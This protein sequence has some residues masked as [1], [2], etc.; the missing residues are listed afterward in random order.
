MTELDE[1]WA[2]FLKNTNRDSE[3]KCSGDLCFEGKGFVQSQINSIVLAGQ[4]QAFFTTLAT[5]TIDNE[6]L[7]IS[8]ELYILVDNQNKPL[9]VLEI[10]SVNII[11]FN[12][13]TFEMVK[14]EGECATMGEWKEKMQEYI[15]DEAHVLGFEYSPDIKLVYQTFKV[16][17]K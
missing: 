5:F 10:E 13:V 8:G 17:Y 9:C 12:E 3:D 14:K 7:P 16:I 6:P 4:K 1:Y 15:E 2:K 11:P